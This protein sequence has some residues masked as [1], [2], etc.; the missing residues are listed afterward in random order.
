[1][2]IGLFLDSEPYS[3]G[4]FQYCQS[5]IDALSN[6]PKEEYH[7]FALYTK[8][9]WGNYLQDF[10]FETRYVRVNPLSKLLSKIGRSSSLRYWRQVSPYLHPVFKSMQAAE[11]DMWIFPS[12]DHYSY[13]FKSKVISAIHDLMHRY[14]D[15]PEINAAGEYESRE[16]LFSN[17]AK[18]ANVIVV[19]STCGREQVMESYNTQKEK[20]RVL[21]Y[22]APPYI[23]KDE[24]Q[25]FDQKYIL[26]PKFLFYPAQFWEHK[27][28]SNL[29]YALSEVKKLHPDIKLV[30][31]GSKKN[32]YEKALSII[33]DLFLEDNILHLGYVEDKYVPILY[34]RARALIMPSF[35]G[36]T[37]IPPLEAM[38]LNCPMAVSGIYGMKEQSGDAAL[39]FDPHSISEIAYYINLLW[40]DDSLC[41][42]LAENGFHRYKKWNQVNFN[43]RFK[44]I[45]DSVSK[46]A[47]PETLV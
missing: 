14:E 18:Y 34:K 9:N 42:R 27:N 41:Q 33:K 1:M 26:P 24:G 38:A 44:A 13:Q 2:R 40:Q 12:Q 35:L 29:F 28:H 7:I 39:Y 45:I 11:C 6:L 4:M 25:D 31:V 17:I 30:L 3:G 43:E 10:D 23:F 16:K 47:S 8:E 36:P 37:N 32:G 21:P 22:V 46:Q 19:D 20:I 15:F 5:I